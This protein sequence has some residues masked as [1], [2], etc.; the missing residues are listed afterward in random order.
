MICCSI[1][2]WTRTTYIVRSWSDPYVVAGHICQLCNS[3]E[4]VE[5]RVIREA[6]IFRK[7]DSW[8]CLA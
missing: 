4:A 6:W 1:Q 2:T 5:S 8:D 3:I 7:W